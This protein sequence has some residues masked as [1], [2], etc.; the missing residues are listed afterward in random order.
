MVRS[1]L[2]CILGAVVGAI[3]GALLLGVPTYFDSGSGF[4]GP[5]SSWTPVA[6]VMGLALG[7]ISGAAIGLLIG[8]VHAR[9]LVGAA[10]GAGFGL[11]LLVILFILGLDPLLDREVAVM[12]VSAIPVGGVVGVLVSAVTNPGQSPNEAEGI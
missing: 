5:N 8:I 3:C 11:L 6:V 12:G 2:S 7:G 10:L 1:V 4:L 9:K